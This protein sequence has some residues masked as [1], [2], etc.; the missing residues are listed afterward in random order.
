MLRTLAGQEGE[1]ERAQGLGSVLTHADISQLGRTQPDVL[2]NRGHD[3]REEFVGGGVL[4]R[5]A[6][7][8]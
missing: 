7:P 6:W 3:G 2:E 4:E 8:Q 5:E 1:E